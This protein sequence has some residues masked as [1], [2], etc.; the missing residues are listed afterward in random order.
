MKD[1]GKETF[2]RVMENKYG[3]EHLNTKETLGLESNRELDFIEDLENLNTVV[4]LEMINLKDQEG[5][6]IVTDKSMRVDLKWGSILD[7]E[8]INGQITLSTKG[9]FWMVKKMDKVYIE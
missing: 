6:Y 1:I 4:V 8:N 5:Q 2:L 9:S 7:L 3:L